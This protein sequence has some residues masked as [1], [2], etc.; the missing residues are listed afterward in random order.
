MDEF[1]FEMDDEA[2]KWL[3]SEEEETDKI[4][5]KMGSLL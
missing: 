5:V 4:I 1:D 2:K 3:V